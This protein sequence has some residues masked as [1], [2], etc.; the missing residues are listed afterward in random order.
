MNNPF[1]AQP[2]PQTLQI[3]RPTLEDLTPGDH[4]ELNAMAREP[5]DF[6]RVELR[7]I[8]LSFSIAPDG[9]IVLTTQCVIPADQVKAPPSRLLIGLGAGGPHAAGQQQALAQWWNDK[10]GVATTPRVQLVTRKG[11]FADGR[12]PEVDV[13]GLLDGLGVTSLTPPDTADGC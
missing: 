3:P 10:V 12:R 5:A 13:D 6:E 7:P 4:A 1:N 2:A 11:A 9:S 8:S